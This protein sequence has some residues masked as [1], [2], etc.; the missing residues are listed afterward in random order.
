MIISRDAEESGTGYYKSGTVSGSFSSSNPVR[1]TSFFARDGGNN[2]LAGT[3]AQVMLWDGKILTQA[4]K[5]ALY[6]SGNGTTS[7]IS[8]WKERGTAI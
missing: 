5:E 4:E 7:I 2:V 1:K 8:A 6:A 3:M